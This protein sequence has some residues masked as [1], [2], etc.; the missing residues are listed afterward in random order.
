MDCSG[1]FGPPGIGLSRNQIINIWLKKE[2]SRLLCE[3]K[4]S[5]HNIYDFKL[6]CTAFTTTD[7]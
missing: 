6:M 3:L 7:L 4:M 5:L 1:F 2:F